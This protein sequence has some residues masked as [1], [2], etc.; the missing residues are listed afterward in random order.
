MTPGILHPLLAYARLGWKRTAGNPLGLV[1]SVL[2]Y[3]L[4][5]AIFWGLWGATPLHE[6]GAAGLTEERLL[7]YLAVTEWIAFAV[8]LP[9]REVEAEIQDGTID[10]RLAHPIAF[11]LTTLAV[12]IGEVGC[13]Y[14]VLGIAGLAA[15]AYAAGAIAPS[16]PGAA[17]LLLS[18]ALAMLLVL[19]WHL[20]IGFAAAWLGISAPTFW[21]WQKCLFVFGGLIMPLTIYPASLG[22]IARAS[23]FAAML[24]APASLMLDGGADGAASTITLQVT[25]LAI[26]VLAAV[27]VERAALRRF[28][29]R[30]T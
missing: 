25:W 8:G 10:M 30:G 13:R 29:E 11:G 5:L 7:A 4:I 26:S 24:F 6:L 27:A 22:A 19:L 16:L 3:W 20:Q 14:V 15:L 18:A 12:W 21:I 17:V 9:Y 23:P 2:L 1:G 28:L